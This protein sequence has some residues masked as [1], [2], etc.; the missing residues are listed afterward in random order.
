MP[1]SKLTCSLPILAMFFSATIALATQANPPSSAPLFHC[2]D[3][4]HLKLSTDFTKIKEAN[5][6]GE[7][8]GEDH[9]DPKF[10]ALG[11]VVDSAQPARVL[12]ANLRTRGMSN[13]FDAAFPKLR[14]EI[15]DEEVLDGTAFK[16]AR[17]FRVN[18]HANEPGENEESGLNAKAPFREALMFDIA[19]ALYLDTPAYRRALIHYVDP[20]HKVDMKR[21][22]L[23]IET[24]KNLAK[25][26]EAREVTTE[27]FLAKPGI[28][29]VI[30]AVFHL[31]HKMIGNE[32]VGLA[33]HDSAMATEFY[34][35][36]FNTIVLERKDMVRVPIVYDLNKSAL[37]LD[38]PAFD[39]KSYAAKEFG[40]TGGEA[41]QVASLSRLRRRFTTEELSRAVKFV[42]S[43]QEQIL[44]VIRAAPLDEACR[45]KVLKQLA[46]FFKVLD[47]AFSLPMIVK[48]DVH[49][50]SDAGMKNH[51]LRENPITGE[52]GTLRLGTPI[53][54]LGKKGK[55]IKV[56]ILDMGFDLSEGEV[57]TGY[58]NDD[59]A[60]GT[61]MPKTLVGTVDDRD[62]VGSN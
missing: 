36:L 25:R 49:F 48:D 24:N 31:F 52:P 39:D 37:V 17:N 20:V 43:R 54:V 18:T 38:Y 21:E 46:T 29:P 53:K 41:L 62:M 55:L 51:K 40:L 3:L 45:T 60:V 11:T 58:I 9:S 15:L 6:D 42:Q 14:V 23:I 32:D 28:N 2:E 57:R 12:K 22:A 35:P 47:L 10:W 56:A 19:R 59:S 5:V 1:M 34:R 8:T 26:L 33:I 50:F 44:K 13:L 61:L 30:G 4:L 7:W 27:E 16:G